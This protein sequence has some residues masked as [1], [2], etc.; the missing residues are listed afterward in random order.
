MAAKSWFDRL[1]KDKHG[2]VVVTQSPNAPIIGW[3]MCAIL[4]RFLADGS[5][6]NGIGWLGAAFLFTWAYLEIS[7]G[8]T[9][10]RRLLGVI[11]MLGLLVG[12]FT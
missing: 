7:D 12:H 4:V 3:A 11:V 9:L 2:K 8:S 10:A 1:F 6:K 5:L